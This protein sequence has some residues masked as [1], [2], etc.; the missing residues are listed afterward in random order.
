[1]GAMKGEA[2]LMFVLCC[3]QPLWSCITD[4]FSIGARRGS[5]NAPLLGA[6]VLVRSCCMS[7]MLSLNPSFHGV[8]C[9]L[10]AIVAFS[11]A[12]AA[13]GCL[14]RRLVRRML[15][16]RVAQLHPRPQHG[17]ASNSVEQKGI[18]WLPTPTTGTWIRN[19]VP[20]SRNKGQREFRGAGEPF[21]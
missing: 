21:N 14:R 17:L 9:R 8:L 1:M 3:S 10:S 7:F 13:V 20:S 4:K 5:V 16:M 11:I 18:C 19:T 12:L 6:E 2:K 15:R